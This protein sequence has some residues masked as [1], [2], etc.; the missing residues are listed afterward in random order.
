[1]GARPRARAS[2]PS[3]FY[4]ALRFASRIA[5]NAFNL[6]APTRRKRPARWSAAST[7]RPGPESL[8]FRLA[9]WAACWRARQ[10]GRGRGRAARPLEQTERRTVARPSSPSSSRATSA[11]RWSKTG[12]LDEADRCSRAR[13]PR[14]SASRPDASYQYALIEARYARLLLARGDEAGRRGA[15]A[16]HAWSVLKARRIADYDETA[17]AGTSSGARWSALGREDGHRA[18][19]RGRAEL[20]AHFGARTCAPPSIASCSARRCSRPAPAEARPMLDE[21]SRALVAAEGNTLPV[22]GARGA[23][24][25]HRIV[26]LRCPQGGAK[27]CSGAARRS[28]DALVP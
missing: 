23:G 2:V 5:Y 13:W 20:R 6:G 1:M 19:A 24:S 3:T 15:R 26:A 7:S 8:R 25:A 27:A 21:A 11:P 18:A 9:C 22:Q 12:A 17:R 4:D 28:G 16:R 10:A 14:W